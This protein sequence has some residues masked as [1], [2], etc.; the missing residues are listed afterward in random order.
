MK[1]IVICAD[2]TWND[3]DQVNDD[4]GK[5]RPTN[6]T[7]IARAT[8]PRAADGVDQVVSY[9]DGIGTRGPLDRITGGAFGRGMEANIRVLYRF[10]VYNYVEGDHIFAFGFSRG[11]FTVRSLLGF[12]QKV[13]LLEK[14]ADYYV[15]EIYGCYENN[16]QPG[17]KEWEHAFRHVTHRRPCPPI[18]FVGVWDTVGALGAPGI[19]GQLFNRKKYKYH[20][21][22]LTPSIQHAFHAMAIDE[23]R[24]PFRP[25]LWKRPQGWSG[26]LEQAWFAGV[27]SNIGGG[28]APDGLANGALHWMAEKAEGLGL[29]LDRAY[30][31]HFTPCFNSKLHDS[32][33]AF[34]R[35]LI[36]IT[37][38]IGGQPSDGEA[39]HESAI[40]RMNLAQCAYQPKNLEACLA[41]TPTFATASTAAVPRGAP[42][43]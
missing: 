16:Y 4:T 6:V 1:R 26:T 43:P 11:A 12:M 24:R 7:K 14:D 13:G 19:L 40:D 39:I 27:H 29:G 41:Q 10:I 8:L 31:A 2:G 25:T 32:M 38:T 20:D 30:L 22:G 23:R 42:C 37:R 15:P 17:S 3:R 28:Y 35:A 18:H 21:V 36:P 34:Y 5:P 9:H 33:T